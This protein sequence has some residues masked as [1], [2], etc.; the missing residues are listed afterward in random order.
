MGG[1]C[2]NT[3]CVPSKALI[4]AAKRAHAHRRAR[5]FGIAAPPA[6]IDFAKVHDHVH[7]VIAAIAPNDSKERFTGLGVRV[8][9]GDGA[10]PDTRHRRGRRRHRD[11]GAALRDRD[12]LVAGAAA[13]PRARRDAVPHQ[14]DGVRSDRACPE[15]LIVI[16]GG[17][18]GLELAQAFRRLGSEVTV[19]EAAQP[20]AAKIPNAPRSC[21]T[22]SRARA[23]TIRSG[24]A[25]AR[26]EAR[27]ARASRSCSAGD[28][29]GDA[30]RAAICWSRPAGAPNVDGL[31]LEP[32]GIALRRRGHRGRP[33][34][35][36]PPTGASMPS[37]TSPAGRS[38]PT[39]PTTTPAS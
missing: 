11:Q 17:P 32:A 39:S 38:S 35:C 26:V 33:A 19:L 5:P 7:D 31:D 27:G 16:G 21:S 20:L 1:E 29:R 25:V 3:G 37:A 14:R 28:E 6:E 23:S 12:R 36:A 30:S 13:D 9:E 10:L 18:I 8:I 4:A 34:A 22:R 2:L 24:V 15:H